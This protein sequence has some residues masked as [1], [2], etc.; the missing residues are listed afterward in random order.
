MRRCIDSSPLITKHS[1]ISKEVTDGSESKASTK[2]SDI[3]SFVSLRR[4]P[5]QDS[6]TAKSTKLD[7]IK[8]L[9]SE[10]DL[11][12][13]P[14]LSI[15]KDLDPRQKI[16]SEKVKKPKAS[17]NSPIE[18]AKKPKNSAKLSVEKAKNS[19]AVPK[20]PNEKAK[21]S[22]AS[23]KSP[24]EKATASDLEL[25]RKFNHMVQYQY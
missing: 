23:P 20:M 1:S 8:N 4:A 5:E 22:K 17:P 19:K 16:P 11:D 12:T 25:M 2:K 13:L 9:S 24:I 10:K 3:P 18:K 15:G 6:G 14:K 7:T 21:K